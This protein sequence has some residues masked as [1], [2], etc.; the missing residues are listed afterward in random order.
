MSEEEEE[1]EEEEESGIASGVGSIGKTHTGILAIRSFF[2]LCQSKDLINQPIIKHIII[3]IH[4]YCY[5]LILISIRTMT[6][7]SKLRRIFSK[8]MV[9]GTRYK[10]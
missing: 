4:L 3:I 1:E 2:W 6:N 9:P 7:F 5:S 8:I 10:F